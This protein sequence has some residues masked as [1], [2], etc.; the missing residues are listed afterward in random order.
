LPDLPTLTVTQ[1]Q[2][3]EIL[4][5]FQDLYGTS[6]PEATATAYKRHLGK[7]VKDVVIAY[8]AKKIDK[9]REV[10]IV[11]MRSQVDSLLGDPSTIV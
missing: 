2:M 5:A 7:T 10:A 3:D 1:A 9:Q 8:E 6:T 11:N 4:A